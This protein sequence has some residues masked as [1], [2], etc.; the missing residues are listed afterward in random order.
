MWSSD[1]LSSERP[2]SW[3]GYGAVI[4]PTA[5]TSRIYGMHFNV[6]LGV[7]DA[8]CIDCGGYCGLYINPA[9]SASVVGQTI[10][11]Q[12]IAYYS[13]GTP[14]D[15]ASS[16]TWTSSNTAVAT[17]ETLGQT[18]PGLYTA[19]AGGSS[20]ITASRSLNAQGVQYSICGGCPG[21]P[22]MSGQAKANVQK[23]GSLN[24]KVLA[25]TVTADDSTGG[26]TAQKTTRHREIG[27]GMWRP[28]L[29]CQRQC[30]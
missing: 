4:I 10:E 30:R 15:F 25:V 18:T 3:A 23:P 21:L 27:A 1:T 6:Q 24:L 26:C 9:P 12:A 13:D 16:C 22:R 2:Q 28:K 8:C 7:T 14:K 19:V 20:T 5:G 11:L 29:V 17:V